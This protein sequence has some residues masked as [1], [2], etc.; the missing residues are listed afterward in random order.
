MTVIE[1][2]LTAEQF[3][4]LPDNGQPRELVRGRLVEMNMPEPRHGYYCANIAGVLREH[5]R[6]H[7]LGRVMTNDSGVITERGPDTV[8]GADVAFYSYTRLPPGPLPEGYL[9]VS[10][11]VIFE[12]RSPTDRWAKIMAKVGEYLNAGVLLVGV[13]DPQ[14]ATLSLYPADELPRV[15]DADDDFSW[16][17]LLGDFR[18]RVQALLE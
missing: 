18:V 2:L 4:L 7:G 15:L 6:A 1:G 8:R 9:D 16:P 11:E 3:R 14:T 5:V 17:E 12:V 10:P 13:L